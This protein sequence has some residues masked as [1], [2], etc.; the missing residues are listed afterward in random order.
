MVP[1]WLKASFPSVWPTPVFRTILFTNTNHGAWAL[2][3]H[4]PH[5]R[6][7]L[8]GLET[9]FHWI[10]SIPPPSLNQNSKANPKYLFGIYNRGWKISLD[11]TGGAFVPGICVSVGKKRSVPQKKWKDL[12]V[13]REMSTSGTGSFKCDPKRFVLYAFA[14]VNHLQNVCK[15]LCRCRSGE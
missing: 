9:V 3:P 15:C 12:E 13:S 11:E 8:W 7:G 4:C 1:D 2:E 5:C 6:G 14:G 10:I